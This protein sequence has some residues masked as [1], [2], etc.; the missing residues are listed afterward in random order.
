MLRVSNICVQ[1]LFADRKSLFQKEKEKEK[2]KEK[3]K[4][5]NKTK[6]KR[7][8]KRKRTRII[9]MTNAMRS[10]NTIRHKSLSFSVRNIKI[11]SISFR[12]SFSRSS[13]K[14]SPFIRHESKKDPKN[15]PL[16]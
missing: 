11:K 8:R 12:L 15:I 5:R 2:V 1:D 14:T 9:I 10:K 7:K 6:K 16:K 3:K 13:K 4:K